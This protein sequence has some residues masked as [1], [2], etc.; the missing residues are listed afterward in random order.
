MAIF[1][2][3]LEGKELLALSTLQNGLV[4]LPGNAVPLHRRSDERCFPYGHSSHGTFIAFHMKKINIPVAL[5]PSFSVR[6]AN[7][8]IYL[9]L[10][11]NIDHLGPLSSGI[12]G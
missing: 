12:S 1:Y 6:V 10:G 4:K 9:L 11:E 2:M 8:T 3:N 7:D 5:L